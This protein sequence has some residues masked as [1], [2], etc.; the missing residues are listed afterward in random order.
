MKML[1]G[2]NDQQAFRFRINAEL[3]EAFRAVGLLADAVQDYLNTIRFNDDAGTERV[4]VSFAFLCRLI[5][6]L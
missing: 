5:V 3:G 1:M 6:D 4:C 2:F